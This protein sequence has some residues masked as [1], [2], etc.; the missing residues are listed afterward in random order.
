MLSYL[1]PYL[2]ESN[3]FLFEPFSTVSPPLESKSE[4]RLTSVRY[5]CGS[6]HSSNLF[7]TL[8]IRAQTSMHCK[9]LLIN[10]GSYWQAIETIREC[11]PKFD[12]VPTLA[13]I[14]IGERKRRERGRE[15]G[16]KDQKGCFTEIKGN[17]QND[18]N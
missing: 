2:S 6:H 17:H 13:Y 10:D 14:A 1:F 18:W 12:I 7:H 5:V 9:D 4:L 11:L 16:R 15:G 8:K 3:Q